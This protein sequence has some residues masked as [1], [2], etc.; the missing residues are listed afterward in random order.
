MKLPVPIKNR[1]IIQRESKSE[2]V[3]LSTFNLWIYEDKPEP[4]FYGKI[5]S[6]PDILTVK[7]GTE[8]LE[9]GMKVMFEPHVSI[10]FECDGIEYVSVR[11]IDILAVIED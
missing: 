6:L 2:H 3:Y 9:I 11:Y 7:E 1:V 8:I 5:V 4:K 10:D